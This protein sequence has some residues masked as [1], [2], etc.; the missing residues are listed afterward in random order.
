MRHVLLDR[1]AHLEGAL[2]ARLELA[3]QLGGEV[4]LTRGHLADHVQPGPRRALHDDAVG[5]RHRHH[6]R[7]DL[8]EPVGAHRADEQR[9]VELGRRRHLD[10]GGEPLP[11]RPSRSLRHVVGPSSAPGPAGDSQPKVRARTTHCGGA[12]SSGRAAAGSPRRASAARTSSRESVRAGARRAGQRRREHLAPLAEGAPHERRP[13]PRMS[14]ALRAAPSPAPTRRANV[15]NADSTRG[16]GRK[17]EA[18]TGRERSRTAGELHEHRD[19]RVGLGRR[20][21]EEP[22]AELLL[23]HHRPARQRRQPDDGRHDQR[24]GDVVGEVGDQRRGRRVERGE[25]GS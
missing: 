13:W 21:R 24:D 1:D 11:F 16:R 3:H 12:S 25:V 15:T 23:H 5:E 17:A 10:A 7:G 9:E 6:Q 22:L 2:Q 19:G 18:G 4:L 14:P 20:H 8:V